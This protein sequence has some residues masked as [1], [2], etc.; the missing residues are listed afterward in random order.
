MKLFCFDIK[1]IGFRCWRPFLKKRILSAWVNREIVLRT[2]SSTTN[3]CHGKIYA[4][5]RH[6][7]ILGSSLAEAKKYCDSIQHIAEDII[8]RKLEEM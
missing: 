3:L 6:M 8:H 2:T 1:Y 5:K 4:I 7:E